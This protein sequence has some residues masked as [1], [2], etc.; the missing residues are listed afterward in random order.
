MP[1]ASAASSNLP[2]QD[3]RSKQE[4][5]FAN[6]FSRDWNLLKEE[7]ERRCDFPGDQGSRPAQILFSV[8][9]RG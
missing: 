5:A 8:N 9:A 6:G 7:K 4:R 1:D 2:S 3:S